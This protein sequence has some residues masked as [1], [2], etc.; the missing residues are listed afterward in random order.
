MSMAH[1]GTEPLIPC[2]THVVRSGATIH[3]H[4]MYYSHGP[5]Y[6]GIIIYY[7]VFHEIF[8]MVFF[9]ANIIGLPGHRNKRKNVLE[10][11]K[12]YYF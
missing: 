1:K 9:V 10:I 2:F 3:S 7:T 11:T 12:M 5:T 6:C 4:I 8:R